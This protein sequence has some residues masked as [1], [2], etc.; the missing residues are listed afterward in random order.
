MF[1]DK[2]IQARFTNK[3]LLIGQCCKYG[4]THFC[5]GIPNKSVDDCATR[6]PRCPNYYNCKIRELSIFDER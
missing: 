2:T 6:K 3:Q 1:N 4:F 5:D